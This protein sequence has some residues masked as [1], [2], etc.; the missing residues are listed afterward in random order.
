MGSSRVS[1][2]EADAGFD[3]PSVDMVVKKTDVVKV[4]SGLRQSISCSYEVLSREKVEVF[5]IDWSGVPT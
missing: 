3:T 4:G 1:A 2:L 5:M